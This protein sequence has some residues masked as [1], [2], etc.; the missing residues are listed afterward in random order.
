M[1]EPPL[2][3]FGDSPPSKDQDQLRTA[4]PATSDMQAGGD[5]ERQ[6]VQE[7]GHRSGPQTDVTPREVAHKE[8][9]V[10]VSGGYPG[11]YAEQCPLGQEV[12]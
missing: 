8:G 3:M 10:Q 5:V 2:Q 11:G 4:G 12:N 9:Q 1:R 6:T 7:K